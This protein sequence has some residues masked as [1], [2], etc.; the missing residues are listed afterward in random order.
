[1]SQPII[2]LGAARSGT[3]YLRDILALGANA[4][5]VPYDINYV[6]RYG[7]E[8]H[9]DD[10]LPVSLLTERKRRFIR[11]QVQRLAKVAPGSDTIV[12]EKTVGSTLRVPFVAAVFPEAKFVHLVR[13]GR[14]VTESSMRQWREPLDFRRLFEKLRDLPLRNAGYPVWFAGNLLK[15]LAVGRGGGKVW[16]PRY[17]GIAADLESGLGLVEL[18]VRQWQASVEM[19]LEGLGAIAPERQIE[20]RYE[21][22]VSGT[23]AL[24]EVAEFCGL[25]DI[26]SVIEAHERLVERRADRKW[27]HALSE[28]EKQKMMIIAMPTL[29]RLGY[30]QPVSGR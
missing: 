29:E 20:L 10:A 8:A 7:S 17:P 9:P 12:F 11:E 1:M 22:L 15:G 24:H 3:K 21:Q 6:W 13:D 27:E 28:G 26:R 30:C 16:G 14:A 23:R 25:Q 2:V 4:A 18:C 5:K 19:A